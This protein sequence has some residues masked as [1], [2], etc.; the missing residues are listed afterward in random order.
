MKRAVLLE[1]C[2]SMEKPATNLYPVLDE[3]AEPT[4]F[5]DDD[6]AD[7]EP[8]D[9][10]LAQAELERFDDAIKIYLRDIQRIPLL[11]AES[12]KDLAQKIEKGDKAARSLSLIHI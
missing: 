5:S 9:E 7:D 10:I 4:L 3:I 11:N 12:E 1:N 2:C 6:D 8:S